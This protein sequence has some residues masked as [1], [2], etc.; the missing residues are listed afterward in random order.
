MQ[1]TIQSLLATS[2]AEEWMRGASRA[3]TRTRRDC[4][5]FASWRGFLGWG[6]GKDGLQEGKSPEKVL[7]Y[8]LTRESLNARQCSERCLVLVTRIGAVDAKTRDSLKENKKILETMRGTDGAG[9]G[10]ELGTDGSWVGGSR[11]TMLQ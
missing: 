10:V 5:T 9:F 1:G 6:A 7:H 11:W 2:I 8:Y 4:L 3:T